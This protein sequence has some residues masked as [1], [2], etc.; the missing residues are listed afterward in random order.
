VVIGGSAGGTR[1][2][3]R[4][5]DDLPAAFPVP[6]LAV[7]HIGRDVGS[8]Y[9]ASLQGRRHLRVMAAE[10]KARPAPGEVHMAPPDYHL[11]VEAD[12]SLALSVDERV[13][14]TRPSIDV[15][16]ESAAEV[17][18]AA[19]V[20]VV[21]SGANADGSRGLVMI[22]EFGGYTVVEDPDTAE[23]SMMP[24]SALAAVTPDH[25]VPVTEIGALLV[26]LCGPAQGDR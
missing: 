2:L 17:H 7:L 26:R 24:A 14:Y 15:L 10:D 8:W 18:G 1:A 16:F 23:V 20:G 4:V 11:L 19:V 13:N 12:G 21:L 22:H 3:R 25:V 5:L 9:P 6:I